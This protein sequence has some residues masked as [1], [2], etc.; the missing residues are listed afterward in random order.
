MSPVVSDTRSTIRRFWNMKYML[1]LEGVL[2]GAIAG[3][4]SILYRLALEWSEKGLHAVLNYSR[5]HLWA[6][7]IWFATLLGMAFLV[8]LLIKRQP[9]ISGSGIPQVEGEISGNLKQNWLQVILYKILGGILCIFGGL[10]LGREGPSIQIGAMT[11]KG[12]SKLLRR[13]HVEEK[14]L[15]TCGASAGLAAAFNAPLAGI[16][17]AL[18]EIHKNFSV[19]VLFSVMA[20]SVTADF[21]SKYVFGLQPVFHFAVDS[22]IPLQHYW[23]IILLGVLIG[24]LG[25]F[26]NFCIL[27][28][29]DFYQ[30]IKKPFRLALPFLT[31][32]VLGFALPQVLGSGHGMID[33]LAEGKLWVSAIIILLVVKFLFSMLSFGS[34][35]PGGIFFPLL[36][37]GA[38]IGG[39][40]GMSAVKLLGLDPHLVNNFI[41]IAMAGYFTAIVRAPITGIVLISEMTGSFSHLLSL[42]VVSIVAYV[43]ADL[44]RS[45][46]I[47]ESLLS[48]ILAKHETPLADDGVA[49][50]LIEDVVQHGS[51]LAG[52]AVGEVRWSK[53]FLL[54]AVRRGGK[55]LIPRGDTVI[56]PGDMLLA[57]VDEKNTAVL[58]RRLHK[59]CTEPPPEEITNR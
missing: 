55:E 16:M 37:L 25:A 57:L 4:I 9:M 39:A 12:I 50:T 3:S 33:L 19:S 42:S 13:L 36:V 1:V 34:G 52:R 11:G 7:V 40:Y 18:E 38:F 58:S 54:V 28:S 8:S 24:I 46:P 45:A 5:Q 49:K 44:L 35:A 56:K 41:I 48:R 10:S 47:Y 21:V 30:K 14:F 27:K 51:P 20:A 29:Q 2:V 32:G 6:A 17:F 22:L 23:L 15:I 31:A 53:N 59:K 43:T 26:Y